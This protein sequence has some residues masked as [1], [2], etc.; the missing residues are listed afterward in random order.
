MPGLQKI[1]T[2]YF[3]GYLKALKQ[4]A[5]K[6]GWTRAQTSAVL[7]ALSDD[8]PLLSTAEAMLD[9]LKAARLRL[10]TWAP[11]EEIVALM[12][13]FSEQIIPKEKNSLTYGDKQLQ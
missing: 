11:P 8:Y 1:N 10:T 3:C 12:L 5:R 2:P 4:Q 9:Y 6:N 13:D 7:R